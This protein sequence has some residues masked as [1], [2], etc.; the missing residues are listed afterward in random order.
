MLE[1]L[2]AETRIETES[3]IHFFTKTVTKTGMKNTV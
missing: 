3:K 1:A 2:E